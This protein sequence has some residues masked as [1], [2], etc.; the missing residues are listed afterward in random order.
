MKPRS[1]KLDPFAARLARLDAE[2]KTL[3]EMQTWLAGERVAVSLGRLSGFLEAQRSESA[4]E[5]MLGQIANGS[6]VCAEVEKSFKR[7]AAPELETLIKL[8]R[9]LILKLSTQ[10][11]VEPALLELVSGAMRPVMDFAK[12]EAKAR[13]QKLDERKVVLLEKKSAA[14]DQ[15]KQAVNSGGLTPETLRKI[16]RELKLL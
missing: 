4:Q 12:L 11:A 8:H 13:D 10:A 6:R 14:F 7:N 15:V 1:S 5:R 3:A 9:V 16:E 2:H